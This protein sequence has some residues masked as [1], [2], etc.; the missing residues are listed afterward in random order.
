MIAPSANFLVAIAAGIRWPTPSWDLHSQACGCTFANRMHWR[1][2][3]AVHRTFIPAPFATRSNSAPNLL[4]LSGT[5]N[6][7][8]R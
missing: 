8:R 6:W 3:I 7:I 5:V 4:L 1:A 2:R